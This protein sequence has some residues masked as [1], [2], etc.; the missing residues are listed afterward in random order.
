[1]SAAEWWTVNL[2]AFYVSNFACRLNTNSH[3]VSIS[4]GIVHAISTFTVIDKH[5]YYVQSNFNPDRHSPSTAHDTCWCQNI[6][7]I[8]LLHIWVRACSWTDFT[9]LRTDTVCCPLYQFVTA[10]QQT[11]RQSLCYAAFVSRFW[12]RRSV[13]RPPATF[14][15]SNLHN[16]AT[17]TSVFPVALTHTVH[18]ISYFVRRLTWK[19]VKELAGCAAL[20]LSSVHYFMW[21]ILIS[22]GRH[23]TALDAVSSANSRSA[24]N[25]PLQ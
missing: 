9:W 3:S 25:D 8:F 7:Y 1:V 18:S 16:T 5:Q 15:C 11:D 23:C 21:Q 22:P 19:R 20:H 12:H 13:R 10:W 17:A 14:C 6:N 4:F 24:T 2:F